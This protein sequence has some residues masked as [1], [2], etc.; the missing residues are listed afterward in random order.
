[1]RIRLFVCELFLFV[2]SFLSEVGVLFVLFCPIHSFSF[3]AMGAFVNRVG[4]ARS[5][6]FSGRREVGTLT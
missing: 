3:S 2:G 1:M 6:I 4:L 5:Q